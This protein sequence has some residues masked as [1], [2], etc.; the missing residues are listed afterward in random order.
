M[1]KPKLLIICST[2]LPAP[3]FIPTYIYNRLE[4]LK[5]E[6]DL[7][8]FSP[9]FPSAKSILKLKN[10]QVNGYNTYRLHS[11]LKLRKFSTYFHSIPVFWALIKIFIKEKPRLIHIHF[12]DNYSWSVRLASAIFKIP[13]LI[14][15]HSSG[16]LT[17]S[18]S[19][20]FKKIFK[21]GL[22]GAGKIFAVSPALCDIIEKTFAIKTIP[23]YNPVNTSVF[24]ISD[25]PENEL[26]LLTGGHNY[27][28][29]DKKNYQLILD[30]SQLLSK[31]KNLKWKWIVFGG[32]NW[33]EF[34]RK[35]I[36]RLNLQS[37]VEIY[38]GIDQK[39]LKD[40]FRISKIF[41]STSKFETFGVVLVEAMASGIPC[42]STPSGGPSSFLNDLNG[43]VIS[44]FKSETLKDAICYINSNYNKY[45]PFL[46]RDFAISNYSIEKYAKQKIS[47]YNE[48]LGK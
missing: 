28:P 36:S 15:E 16:F 27:L 18:Q 48:I 9:L 46:I 22:K 21:F 44:D 32:G 8:V 41:V 43:I 5:S 34:F 7:V 10:E 33:H 20:F 29:D 40:F 38:E 3:Q 12:S 13:Y 26:I 1:S 37:Y 6:F 25:K 47:I 39:K 17:L 2:S 11:S 19:I 23:F 42:I 24:M 4:G 30:T 35:E 31:Q 45:N 14:T